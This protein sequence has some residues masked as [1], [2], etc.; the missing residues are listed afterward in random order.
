MVFSRLDSGQLDA[1]MEMSNIGVGH[2]ATALSQLL[3]TSVHIQVPQVAV[4][5]I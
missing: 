5:E 2:A 4:V 1:L 3:G